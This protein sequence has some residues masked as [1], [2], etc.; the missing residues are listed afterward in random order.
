MERQS[1]T[2]GEGVWGVSV[3]IGNGEACWVQEVQGCW[4]GAQ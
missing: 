4:W 3:V 2:G 1:D